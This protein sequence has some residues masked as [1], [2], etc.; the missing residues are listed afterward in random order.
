MKPDEHE[1]DEDIDIEIEDE[2]IE[3]FPHPPPMP[4]ERHHRI[5]IKRPPFGP[6]GDFIDPMGPRKS[7]IIERFGKHGRKKSKCLMI[8]FY[9]EDDNKVM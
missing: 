7:V 3:E 5:V 6:S 8:N 4:H 9:D 2:E 1:F